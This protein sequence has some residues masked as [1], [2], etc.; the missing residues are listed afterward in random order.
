MSAAK[1]RRARTRGNRDGRPYK[2]QDG[3]W[4]AVG[5]YPDGKRKPCYGQTSTEA[6][7]KRK[8]FYAELQ[9]QQPITIG[10]TLTVR[11]Y[12]L[13]WVTVTLPQLMQAGRLDENTLESYQS[14]SRL[15][16]V[17]HLGHIKLVELGT[18]DIRQ[19]LLAL[20][21]KPNGNSRRTL[22]PGETELP[23]PKKLASSTQARAHTVLRRA[24]AAAVEDELVKRNVC[25][26]VKGPAIRQKKTEA[27][28]PAQAAV[29]LA[30]ASDHRLFAYWIIVLALG[31]R[32]GEGLGFRWHRIDLDAGT[33][34]LR[35]QVYRVRVSDPVT[36]K[37]T[38]TVKEKDL[39]T[40][41]S[42]AS[43]QMPPSAVLAL[44]AHR[45]A[46]AAERLA[47]KV[48]LDDDLVFTDEI[49]GPLKPGH[50]LNEWLKVCEQ[51][52]VGRWTLRAL[53]HA[54]ATFMFAQGI[55]LKV[56]QKTLR[57]TRL[58]TTADVYTDVLEELRTGAT[59]A[60]EN[61]I[62][63]MVGPAQAES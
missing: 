10:N 52:G 40:E 3:K 33:V 31:L 57:H 13:Q 49:G 2:R 30:T 11:Q 19:W 42:R 35:K 37:G 9:A 16:I 36:G 20:A 26:L 18:N 48:W 21:E 60:M 43:M 46:Q 14:M 62:G 4:V 5:Y 54:A 15:H 6:A 55:E 25:A 22:R 24:L 28:T 8:Q 56:V 44:R 27:P 29:L 39:K 7:E 34:R 63:P 58:S 47:A 61:I 59:V 38:S 17:P 41:E 45:K 53:R 12:M 50:V 1:P 23:P 32:R 51:A